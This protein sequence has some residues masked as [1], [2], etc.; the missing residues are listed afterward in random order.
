MSLLLQRR[1]HDA[2]TELAA[3]VI[4]TPSINISLLRSSHDEPLYQ[5]LLHAPLL[6]KV[7]DFADGVYYSSGWDDETFMA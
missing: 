2:P 1:S 5:K 4:T 3:L 7:L 6:G